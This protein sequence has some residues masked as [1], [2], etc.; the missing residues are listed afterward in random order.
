MCSELKVNK[1]YIMDSVGKGLKFRPHT[2][3]GPYK[4]EQGH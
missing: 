1:L 2:Q 3:K 4:K